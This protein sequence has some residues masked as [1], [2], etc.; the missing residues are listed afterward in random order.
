MVWVQVFKEYH[1][2]DLLEVSC[3]ANDRDL[4]YLRF[5]TSKVVPQAPTA[6][7]AEGNDQLAGPTTAGTT[8]VTIRDSRTNALIKNVRE[9]LRKM[10]CGVHPYFDVKIVIPP[11]QYVISMHPQIFF[12]KIGKFGDKN[13][14][15][16]QFLNLAWSAL[17][18]H[19]TS[20]KPQLIYIDESFNAQ[21]IRLPLDF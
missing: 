5:R 18:Y 2:L 15:F 9:S 1:L 6:V 16:G 8:L 19:A 7:P 14:K 12:L 3:A 17:A 10:T 21:N 11:D 4:I 20:L 13:F